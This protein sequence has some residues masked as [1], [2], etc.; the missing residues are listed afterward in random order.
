MKPDVHYTGLWL[1][2]KGLVRALATGRLH[3]TGSIALTASEKFLM[4]NQNRTLAQNLAAQ[5]RTIDMYKKHE[6]AVTRATILAAFGCNF[7][8]DIGIETGINLEALIESARLAEDIVGHPL[9]GSVMKGGSLLKYRR[10]C[11]AA[12]SA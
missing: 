2:D 5:H 11:E 1:N 4:R 8:G 3:V 9:P 6:I 10:S 12:T 7:E